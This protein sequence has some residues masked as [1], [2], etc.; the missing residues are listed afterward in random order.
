M[1]VFLERVSWLVSDIMG[2]DEMVGSDPEMQ[3]FQLK[4]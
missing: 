4:V 2:C 1:V 3:G